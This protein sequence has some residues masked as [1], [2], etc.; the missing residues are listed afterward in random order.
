MDRIDMWVPV[1]HVDYQTLSEKN[2]SESSA[3]VRNRVKQARDFAK[4]RFEK[5]DTVSISLNKDIQ[6]KDME[7]CLHLTEK[8]S[9]IMRTFSEKSSLSPRSYHRV[10]RLARTI[11]DL[12]QSETIEE[13]D[14]L[15]AFQYR[16]KLYGERV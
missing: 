10:L 16:P 13:K 1:V 2:T 4:K 5:S 9:Q 6:P 15:E 7:K 8:A 14:I 3:S 12:R 11:A